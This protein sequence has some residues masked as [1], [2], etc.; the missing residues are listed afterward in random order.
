M[1][2][3]RHSGYVDGRNSSMRPKKEMAGKEEV[4]N[5]KNSWK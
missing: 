1:T 4:M 2:T 5:V 3:L